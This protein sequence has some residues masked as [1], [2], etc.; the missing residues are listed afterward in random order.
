MYCSLNYLPDGFVCRLAVSSHLHVVSA[1]AQTHHEAFAPMPSVGPPYLSPVNQ[2]LGINPDNSIF[3]SL[4]RK[5][6][7]QF[8]M[9]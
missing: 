3:L 6:M 5:Y 4:G 1:C 9:P 8:Y 7:K 2:Q